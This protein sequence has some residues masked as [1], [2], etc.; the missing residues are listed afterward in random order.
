VLTD[1]AKGEHDEHITYD[2]T[3]VEQIKSIPDEAIHRN[4]DL[5]LLAADKEGESR[6]GS[7][8]STASDLVF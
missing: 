5:T 6:P 1:D 8:S 2:D 7:H 3:D 4:V